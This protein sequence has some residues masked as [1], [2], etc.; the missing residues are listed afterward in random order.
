MTEAYTQGKDEI[1][2]IQHYDTPM[3]GT[4]LY[5][6]T[7]EMPLEPDKQQLN[8]NLTSGR[9]RDFNLGYTYQLSPMALQNITLT[10]PTDGSRSYGLSLLQVLTFHLNEDWDHHW[11]LGLAFRSETTFFLATSLIY[12]LHD[13]FN[14]LTEVLLETDKET[15]ITLN[16]GLRSSFKFKWKNTEM[17]PGLAF[18]MEIKKDPINFGVFLYLSFESEFI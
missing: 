1:Q 3:E 9:D 10:T 12:L 14:L 7:F 5:D 16:P 13:R 2:F 8:L 4:Y 15:S 6:L 17:V 11:N 18:P